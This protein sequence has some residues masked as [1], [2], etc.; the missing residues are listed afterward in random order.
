M[1]VPGNPLET[2]NLIYLGIDQFYISTD[3]RPV[4]T[5]LGSCV[6]IVMADPLR[7]IFGVNH[8]L[9]PTT[10][11]PLSQALL[12]K[13]KVI[14][15]PSVVII[16]GGSH[17]F[18]ASQIGQANIDCARDFAAHEGLRV[19]FEDVG[20]QTGRTIQVEMPSG[21]P[22]IKVRHHELPWEK[23]D[24]KQGESALESSRKAYEFILEMTKK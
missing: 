3:R 17:L 18:G 1:S 6:G 16:A 2:A 19:I 11:L 5:G 21:E 20:G 15:S 9:T 14:C 12:S 23:V 10:G 7:G 4:R 24:K 22:A 13:L 8:Y